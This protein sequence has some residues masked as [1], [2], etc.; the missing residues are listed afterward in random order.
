MPKI[1][2]YKTYYWLIIGFL[3]M[4]LCDKQSWAQV[5]VA[6]YPWNGLAAVST[7]PNKPVWVDFRLQ[8][9]TL[10]GSLSTE[11]LPLVNV[12][13]RESYQVYMGG[14]LRFNFIG[15]LAGQTKNII[16]GYSLNVGTRVSPFVQA[17]NVKIAFE[18]SPFIARKFDSGVLKSNFG[19]VYVF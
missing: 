7:N 9:N 1:G 15:V 11:V 17:R 18:L 19:L 14:G 3:S 10:F 8:T 6:Y 2:L 12:K 4:V 16:E 5:S 13:Q